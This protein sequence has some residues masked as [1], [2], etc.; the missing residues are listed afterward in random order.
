[1][2]GQAEGP[3]RSLHRTIY[4]RDVCGIVSIS[5]SNNAFGTAQAHFEL[6]IFPNREKWALEKEREYTVTCRVEAENFR[7]G[8]TW[9]YRMKWNGEFPNKGDELITSVQIDR[10]CSKP[11]ADW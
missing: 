2:Y 11:G 5:K 7:S 4:N 9:T 6:V 1:M 8:K 3:A 10:L